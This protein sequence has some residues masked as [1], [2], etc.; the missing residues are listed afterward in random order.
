MRRFATVPPPQTLPTE[1][2]EIGDQ[3][4]IRV[5]S[6]LADD[7][8]R[9]LLHGDTF[10]IF[11]RYGDIAPIGFGKQG[12]FQRDTRHLSRLE[13]RICGTRPLLL[14]STVRD[15]NI[16]L[17]VDLTNPDLELPSGKSL[18]RGTLHIFRT[19]FLSDGV[20]FER[21]VIHNYGEV[22]A[23]VDLTMAFGADFS[24]IFEVRGQ[25]RQRRGTLLPTEAETP[26]ITF[27][28]VG[29]DN[30]TRNTRVHSSVAPSGISESKLTFPIHVEPSEEIAI[31]LN[32][33]CES[34]GTQQRSANYDENLARVTN[35][36]ASS[37]LADVDIY[38]S[39]EL[40]NDWINRSRAD[41][42]MLITSTSFGP[43]PYAGVPWFSTVFG[44]DGI[45]TALELLW[46]APSVA[47]GVLSYL[48]A[49]QATSVDADRDAEPG[50]ILHEIR[51][52]E[53][54][55]L[56]EVPFGRYYGSVDSTPLFLVLAGAYYERTADL[57]FLKSIWP[58]L[59]AA[60]TWIDS[61]GDVDGDGFVEYAR[62]TETGL[63]QQGWKDSHDSIFHAD[64]RL[65][66]APIALCEVQAYVF[67]AK[68]RIARVADDLGFREKA[69][70]LRTQAADLRKNF[71]E[72]FWS[73]EL[74]TL[75][76]ALDGDKRQCRVRSSNAGQCLFS[77]IASPMHAQRT[78]E[79]LQSPSSF[80]G[81]G[82]RT[83]TTAEKRYNP[84]SYHNGSVWPHDNALI[85]F[86]CTSRRDKQLASQIML[87]LFDLSIFTELHR[88][89]EL[90]CGFPRRQGKG[91]T[92]YPVACSPQAWAAGAV[93]L[94]LQSCLGLSIRAEESRIYLT[95][96]TLPEAL[97]S[98]RIRNIKVGNASVDLNFER[99]AE[100]VAVD[101]LRRSGD[102]EIITTN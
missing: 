83:I 64:G 71:E 77:D 39:N 21:I 47:K 20:C 43:Y 4:Y 17:G 48:A 42:E 10:A 40:F 50:K 98:V 59:E 60:L 26:S 5:H 85:A 90:I 2:L 15:D 8:T 16:L 14:S 32:I 7:R 97:P 66:R 96:P 44:R 86:G 12:L 36:R 41:L 89:P 79:T 31:S 82:I 6:S 38:T 63:S 23:D 75:A 9:V 100:T 91:P 56:R 92:L 25:E 61:F 95:Y 62:Q 45:I 24:D 101:I 81:W 78:I 80:S 74:S 3:F 37:P 57:E 93:F 11:D 73:D 70:V 34:D 53:M 88:L 84:M 19:K 22:F 29:L 65:A 55:Q 54:A 28:Y 1:I 18:A 67:A 30:V 49:T 94:L 46:L 87:G 69:E 72:A 99:H 58:N 76:L 52:G 13:L 51:Q 35:E 27:S 102:V 33:A 68:S